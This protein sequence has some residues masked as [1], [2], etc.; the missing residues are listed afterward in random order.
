MERCLPKGPASKN[1]DATQTIINGPA[2]VMTTID[3]TGRLLSFIEEVSS[4][5]NTEKWRSWTMEGAG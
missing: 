5:G 3:V 4:E 2:V 1:A